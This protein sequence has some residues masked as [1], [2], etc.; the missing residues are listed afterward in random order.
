MY[1]APWSGVHGWGA[2]K[3]PHNPKRNAQWPAT[4][5]RYTLVYGAWW[6]SLKGTEEAGGDHWETWHY[7]SSFLANWRGPRLANMIT[8]YKKTWKEDPGNSRPV[9]QALVLGK[10]MDNLECHHTTHAGQP[11]NQTQPDGVMK[12][13]SCLTNT[14]SFSGKWATL[15][16]K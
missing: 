13:R 6:D 5:L 16:F 8:I 14:T 1:S 4:S 10:D 15:S 11:G 3:S 12:S 7:L 9:N 2:E